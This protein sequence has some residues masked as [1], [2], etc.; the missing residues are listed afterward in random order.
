VFLGIEFDT[1]DMVMRLPQEKNSD[2]R[3]QIAFFINSKKSYLEGIAILNWEIILGRLCLKEY[4]F[5]PN[6]LASTPVPTYD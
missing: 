6:P 5:P 4:K 3:K 1:V 2:L